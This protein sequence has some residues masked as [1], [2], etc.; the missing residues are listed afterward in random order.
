VVVVAVQ[1]KLFRVLL[2]MVEEQVLQ[3]VTQL[4]VLQ[5]LVEVAVVQD[6]EAQL[7]MAVMADQA[8]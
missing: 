7:L 1:D 6:M 2:A 5:T 8:L 3:Q 4:L